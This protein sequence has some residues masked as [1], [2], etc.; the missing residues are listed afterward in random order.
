MEKLYE[1][2]VHLQSRL[3]AVHQPDELLIEVLRNSKDSKTKS[4]AP[5]FTQQPE[6]NFRDISAW[7]SASA[8]PAPA[9]CVFPRN[10]LFS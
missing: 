2:A 9:A 1:K 3:D 8:H 4:K 7:P 6:G 5:P 10:F